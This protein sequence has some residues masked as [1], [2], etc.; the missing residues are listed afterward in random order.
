MK[1]FWSRLVW[2]GL[3]LGL[4]YA[5]PAGAQQNGTAAPPKA[6]SPPGSTAAK[7]APGIASKAYELEN[8][9]ALALSEDQKAR[10]KAIRED[11]GLQI[12]AVEK[13][14]TL[15]A[16]QKERK[17]KLIHKETRAK[18]FSVLTP[19]QQKTWGAE[20]H[21]R[22]EARTPTSKPQPQ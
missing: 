19:D 8:D 11:A 20:Q 14:A 2:I 4:A 10:I 13:D 15:T 5:T 7:P 22:H 16:D 9:P 12:Q 17:V 18:T 1:T 6:A 3:L 21:E